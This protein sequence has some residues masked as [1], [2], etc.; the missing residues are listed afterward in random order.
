MREK[1][2]CSR[3]VLIIVSLIIISCN[4]LSGTQSTD[5]PTSPTAT[6]GRAVEPVGTVK[7][8]EEPPE[9]EP[10]GQNTSPSHSGIEEKPLSNQGPWFVF[11][12][13]TMLY[14]VN[15]DGSG[16]TPISDANPYS[17]TDLEYSAAAR[18]GRLAMI[19]SDEERIMTGLTLQIITLP[20]LS[21]TSIPL[22]TEENEVDPASPF[23]DERVEAALSIVHGESLAWS[24][25]SEKLAFFGAMDGPSADLYV[26]DIGEESLLRLTDGPTQGA[27]TLWSPDGEFIAHVGVTGFGSGAG[28]TMD[29][30]WLAAA[31]DSGVEELYDVPERSGSEVL[32]GWLDEETLLV[33]S[34]FMNCGSKDLRTYN[35]NTGETEIIWPDFFQT[36]RFASETRTVLFSVTEDIVRCNTSQQHGI[37]MVDTDSTNPLR[38]MEDG[39]YTIEWFQ[40]VELFA[41]TVQGGYISISSAGEII[42]LE[43]PSD[44]IGMPWMAPVTYRMAWTGAGCWVGSVT[45]GLDNP[46][47]QIYTGET[48]Y[49]AW[50]RDGDTLLFF[51]KEGLHTAAAPDFTPVLAAPDITS[52]E[53]VWVL[54]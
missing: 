27:Y 41:A 25:D 35:T 48:T 23:K 14:A 10:T 29:R 22:T 19:V 42:D 40:D 32:L 46:L 12:T 13:D 43:K 1:P 54:P 52:S 16:L 37:F 8:T 3:L 45:S 26:Y 51:S 44:S 34:W 38:I 11:S 6:E 50:S 31:D 4:V 20:S 39:S 47:E 2:S 7:E 28:W 21:V 18:G 33:H 49:A 5:M 24:P 9:P 30:I 36:V 17:W 15:P 53:G